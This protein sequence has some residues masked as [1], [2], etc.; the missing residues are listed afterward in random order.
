MSNSLNKSVEPLNSLTSE[1]VFS[2]PSYLRIITHGRLRTVPSLM[3]LTDT[4]VTDGITRIKEK[5]KEINYPMMISILFNAFTEKSYL[6]RIFSSGRFGFDRVYADSGG[7][8]MVTL[9][10]TANHQAKQDV[11]AIQAQADLAMCFDEIPVKNEGFAGRSSYLDKVFM[12]EEHAKCAKETCDNVISQIDYFR[13]VGSSTKI[14]F[15]VQGNT[16]KDMSEWF[17]IAIKTIPKDYWDHIG[18]LAIGGV[19]MGGGQKEDVE[20]MIVYRQLRDDFGTE[21]TKKHLHMLGV[22]SIMRLHPMVILRNSGLIPEDTHVSYD[23]STLSMAYTYG[24]FMTKDGDYQRDTPLWEK[25]FQD[26]YNAITPIF[27]DYGYTQK[28]IN[29]YYDQVMKDMLCHKKIYSDH[30]DDRLR[31]VH[32]CFTAL[33]NIFQIINFT[34]SLHRLYVNWD[35]GNDPIGMLKMVKNVD[36]FYEWERVYGP[37]VS[38]KRL[39][40]KKA[41]ILEEMIFE[42]TNGEKV[43]LPKVTNKRSK[44]T[45]SAFWEE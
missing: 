35:K 3:K 32:H 36:D 26:Y 34:H 27:L 12:Y 39:S 21:Y 25:G 13:K 16:F 44:A 31:V 9:G 7:L 20:K 30:E 28:E 6:E 15:I 10:M 19:C 17:E 11:Y 24:K 1:F 2:A 42:Q 4:I 8:Q 33:S 38:S 40:R 41:S 18:G 29:G 37:L 23:S 45:L 43:T 22:G 5:L 14:F